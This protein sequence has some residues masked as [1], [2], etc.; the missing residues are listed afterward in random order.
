LV[1]FD[2]IA[3]SGFTP[4]DSFDLGASG[5]MPDD[6]FDLV[7]SGFIPDEKSSRMNRDAT[8]FF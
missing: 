4:D 3:A 5:F 1:S 8:F 7:A 6:S 2:L